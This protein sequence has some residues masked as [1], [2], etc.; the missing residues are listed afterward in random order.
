MHTHSGFKLSKVSSWRPSLGAKRKGC[1]CFAYNWQL[2]VYSGVFLLTVVFGS[3][4]LTIA[5][6]AIT[7]GAFLFRIGAFLLTTG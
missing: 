6:F 3:F 7:I 4:L 5:A 1:N 2:P